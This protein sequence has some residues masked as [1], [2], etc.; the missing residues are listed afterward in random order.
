MSDEARE[1]AVYENWIPP[2]DRR[3]DDEFYDINLIQPIR[4][5]ELE[6]DGSLQI[7]TEIEG[8]GDLVE[9]TDTIYYKHSTRFDNG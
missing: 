1:K 7:L 4:I 5:E 3:P 8:T 9:D 6:E 2:S